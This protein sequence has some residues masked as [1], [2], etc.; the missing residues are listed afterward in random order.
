[1]GL[2]LEQLRLEQLELLAAIMLGLG[3]T[4]VVFV[5][6]RPIVGLGLGRWMGLKRVGSFVC[7]RRGLLVP[8]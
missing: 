8:Q 7:I 1:M 5:M 4:V 6:V 2:G 3:P